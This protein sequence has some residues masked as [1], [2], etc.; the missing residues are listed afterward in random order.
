MSTTMQKSEF[1]LDLIV[2]SAKESGDSSI[3]E[4]FIPEI[5]ELIYKFTQTGQ[6]GMSAPYTARV[7]SQTIEKLCLHKPLSP[8]TG[9]DSEWKEISDFMFTNKELKEGKKEYQNKRCGSIFKK[10]GNKIT[11]CDAIVWQGEDEYDTFAGTVENIS[12]SQEITLPFFP[13]TFY[14]DVYREFYNEKKHGKDARV[15]SCQGGD[16]VYFVKNKE[17]LNEALNYFKNSK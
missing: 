6:S 12:S 16:F 4:P 15:V 3:V 9:D 7:I 1:E 8:I 14:I 10:E 5:L 13:K 11:F 2:K 17:Q